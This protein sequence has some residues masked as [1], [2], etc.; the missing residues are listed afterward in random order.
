VAIR[1]RRDLWETVVQL[2][3]LDSRVRP[4]LLDSLGLPD[5]QVQRDFQETLETRAM[6]GKPE[7]AVLRATLG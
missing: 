6:Q 2:E 1:V 5:S 3:Y 4:V 7:Y